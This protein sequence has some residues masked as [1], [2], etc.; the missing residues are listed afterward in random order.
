MPL[1]KE[2]RA[3][4]ILDSR[5]ESTIETEIVLD[6]KISATASVPSGASTG[7]YEAKIA[8]SESGATKDDDITK[9]IENVEVISTDLIKKDPQDQKEIDNIILELDGT[10]TKAH[11]GANATLSVSLATAKVAAKMLHV[12]LWKYIGN[13]FEYKSAY[14]IPTPM[15]NLIE[16]GKHSDN[17]L[18]FQEFLVIPSSS[19]S[20][21]KALQIGQKIYHRLKKQL[22][23]Q[24]F[25]TLTADEGGFAPELGSNENALKLL[26][27]VIES[28]GYKLGENIFLGIDAASSSF[29]KDSKYEVDELGGQQAASQLVKFYEN[30]IKNY[31]LIYIEDPLSE[32]D[33]KGWKKVFK[34]LGDKIQIVGDDLTTTN[35]H[36]LQMALDES[37][38]NGIIIKPNQIGTLTETLAVVKIAQHKGLKVTVSHRSGETEDTFIADLAVGIGADQVKFGAPSRERVIKYN[39]LLKIEEELNASAGNYI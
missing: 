22:A 31:S 5:G 32:N 18:E 8:R 25:S 38:I 2:V 16:G 14:S 13:L 36:R 26:R 24:N 7:I 37:T 11:L 34:D 20:F 33:I 3:R 27:S 10:Q 6:N 39:R 12:P 15:F 19:Q 35:P 28:K 4:K 23:S 17:L 9:A 29:V 1:I 21:S 30:L